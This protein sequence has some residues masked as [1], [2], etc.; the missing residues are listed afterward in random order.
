MIK[1]F[2]IFAVCALSLS[3]MVACGDPGNDP[4][5]PTDPTQK[6]DDDNKDDDPG[7]EPKV[8]VSLTVSDITRMEAT[9]EAKASDKNAYVQTEIVAKSVADKLGGIEGYIKD[10]LNK[11]TA[12]YAKWGELLAAN[13]GIADYAG[14]LQDNLIA[15]GCKCPAMKKGSKK[16]TDNR[17]LAD[18]K[19]IA[20]AYI[21]D[22]KTFEY[23]GLVTKEFT[24]KALAPSSNVISIEFN[25]GKVTFTPTNS[26]PY[27]ADIVGQRTLKRSGLTTEEYIKRAIAQQFEDGY[28]SFYFH[29]AKYEYDYTDKLRSLNEGSYL[30]YAVGYDGGITTDIFGIDVSF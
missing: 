24:T 17:L 12:L 23:S 30:I 4:E 9:I 13:Y 27:F 16:L 11:Y 22:M 7:K 8:T 5:D 25:E 18:T 1:K 21:M 2:F 20:Y 14:F 19:Y 15:V 6:D 29:T 3:M 26:D 10:T 28:L